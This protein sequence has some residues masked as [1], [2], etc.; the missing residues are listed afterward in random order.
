MKNFKI[1]NLIMVLLLVVTLITGC[2]SNSN[3]PSTGGEKKEVTVFK[4]ANGSAI[5]DE[6]D[7]SLQEFAKLVDQKSN[8][9]MKV[10]VYSGGTLGT[11]RDTIEGLEPESFR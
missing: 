8:G 10:E 4:L 9:T 2:S 1:L 6:R 3:Q 7:Q 5:G 11:W